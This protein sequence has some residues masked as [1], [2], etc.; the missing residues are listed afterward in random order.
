MKQK[1]E[2]M[3]P[4]DPAFELNPLAPPSVLSPVALPGSE[5][6]HHNAEKE[7]ALG[8]TSLTSPGITDI[9]AEHGPLIRPS[10]LKSTAIIINLAVIGFLNNDGVWHPHQCSTVIHG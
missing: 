2:P 1:D 7:D 10:K 5:K 6:D 8:T 9:P 4:S 3:L